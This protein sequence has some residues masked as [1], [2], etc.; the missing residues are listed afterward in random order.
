M[1]NICLSWLPIM[2]SKVGELNALV[3][4]TDMKS[5]SIPFFGGVEKERMKYK[6]F[7][8]FF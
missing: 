7:G 1:P 5:A 6:N 8:W 2:I 3:M 4:G